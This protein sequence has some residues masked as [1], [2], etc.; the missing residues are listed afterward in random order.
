MVVKYLKINDSLLY[1]LTGWDRY[2]FRLCVDR[3]IMSSNSSELD[4]V[5]G[6]EL[7]EVISVLGS[8]SSR[9]GE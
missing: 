6:E 8:I 3:E 5:S 1:N 9:G 7:L 2:A 4:K